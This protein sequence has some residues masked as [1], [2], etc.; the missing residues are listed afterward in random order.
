MQSQNIPC[1]VR[2]HEEL[3]C[4]RDVYRDMREALPSNGHRRNVTCLY[5][6]CRFRPHYTVLIKSRTC[7]SSD[8]LPPPIETSLVSSHALP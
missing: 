4:M 5:W 7:G 3:N 1:P 2:C 6:Q 8:S